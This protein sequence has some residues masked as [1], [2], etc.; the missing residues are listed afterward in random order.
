MQLNLF[1]WIVFLGL[2]LI[3]G[4]VSWRS[5]RTPRSHGFFRFFAWECIAALLA[6]NLRLWFVE[7][8]SWHQWISWLLLFSSLVPLTFG[9]L[10]LKK[11][12]NA[13]MARSSEPELL[14][15]EKTTQLVTSGIFHFIRHPLY[16]SL[17]LLTWGIFFKSLHWL[18]AILAITS[19]LFLFMTAWADEKECM[20]YFG[21]EYAAYMQKTKRFI[22]FLF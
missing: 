9:V 10:T 13:T 8:W 15:F 1:S 18:G 17:L 7:P 16:S 2:S 6:L 22:P 3:V 5:L 4:L 12:G 20:R 19:T 14:T 11:R 21:S